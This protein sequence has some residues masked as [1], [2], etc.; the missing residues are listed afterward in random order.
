MKIILFSLTA[1]LLII[2]VQ[3]LEQT[4]TNIK[5]AAAAASQGEAY[6]KC[7]KV[8]N[9]KYSCRCG[10]KKVIYDRVRQACINGKV[11]KR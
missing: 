1:V 2:V 11:V 3:C 6:D 9:G 5:Q 10:K 8:K 4:E 7:Q